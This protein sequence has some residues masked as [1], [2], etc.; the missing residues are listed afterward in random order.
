MRAH[1]DQC[2]FSSTYFWCLHVHQCERG[3][4]IFFISI[5]VTNHVPFCMFAQLNKFV[6]KRKC[7]PDKAYLFN[8]SSYQ[9]YGMQLFSRSCLVCDL[10]RFLIPYSSL[11]QHSC[12]L[13]FCFTLLL[14]PYEFILRKKSFRENEFEIYTIKQIPV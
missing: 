3:Q 12:S 11:G 1:A 5:T 2:C 14:A 4:T 8:R 13:V 9:R 10:M 7:K 6:V